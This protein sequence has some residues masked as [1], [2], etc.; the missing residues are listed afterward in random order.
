MSKIF[1]SYRRQDSPGFAGRICDHVSRHFG[2]DAVFRDVEVLEG[3]VDFVDAINSALALCGAF[4]LVIGPRW[5]G[6]TD[7]RGRK[8]LELPGDFVRMELANALAR[9][10]RV[11]PLLVDGA[12]MPA[13]DDLPEDLKAIVRRHAIEITDGRFESDIEQ[14]IRSLES[15]LGRPSR[16]A[17]VVSSPSAPAPAPM[18]TSSGGAVPNYLV[19][20]IVSTACLCMP[21]GIVAIVQSNKAAAAV[22]AGDLATAQ[23]CAASARKWNLLSLGLGAVAWVIGMIAA[24][25]SAQQ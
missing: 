10:I 6:A 15:A 14:V 12:T 16:M 4:I 18:A 2:D 3:G 7:A 21:L 22:V 9:Q 23:A 8:R 17:P 5:L 25:L 20:S 13:V 19:W 1:I 24:A 11:I